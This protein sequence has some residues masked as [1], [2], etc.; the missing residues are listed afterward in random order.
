MDTPI[1]A[2]TPDS[3]DGRLES[4]KPDGRTTPRSEPVGNPTVA[5]EGGY[6]FAPATPLPIAAPQS[7]HATR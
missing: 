7:V 1:S 4:D 5:G 2:G 6:A 3:A